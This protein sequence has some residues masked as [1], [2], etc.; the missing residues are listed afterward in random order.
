MNIGAFQ[1]SLQDKHECDRCGPNIV[2]Q[3]TDAA[4]HV[5]HILKGNKP[6][7]LPVQ[8]PTT[9]ELVIDLTTAKAI[10]RTILEP[11]SLLADE[12]MKPSDQNPRRQAVRLGQHSADKRWKL[13]ALLQPIS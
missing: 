4:D 12:A 8:A 13:A 5:E 11:T 6:T 10:G 7:D 3:Y 1:A 9:F 2:D